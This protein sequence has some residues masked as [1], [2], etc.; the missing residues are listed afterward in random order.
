MRRVQYGKEKKGD[1]SR[2]TVGIVVSDYNSDI[3][4]ALLRGALQTLSRWKVRKEN[5]IVRHVPGGFEIPFGCLQL[6]RFKK[7]DAIISLG[8]I[9]KG[10]TKH[11]EYIAS[12]AS[13]GIM[14]LSLKYGI[15]ISFGI[16]TP[17]TIEQA[18]IRSRDKE[19]KGIEAAEA[20]LTMALHK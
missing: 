3:T 10:E 6:I 16:L 4:H 14:R 9:L 5:I 1:A 20:A 17:N 7:P 2:L 12:A 13:Q 19:N 15:P 18:R 11:D 8:C